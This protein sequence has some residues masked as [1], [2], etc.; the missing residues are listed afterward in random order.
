[1]DIRPYARPVSGPTVYA[2]RVLPVPAAAPVEPD[3]LLGPALQIEPVQVEPVQIEPA[4]I[5]P[6][7]IET[8]RSIETVR[9]IEPEPPETPFV[10]PQSPSTASPAMESTEPVLGDEPDLDLPW[11]T[12][13]L[14]EEAEPGPAS[15]ALL[16]PLPVAADVPTSNTNI[17]SDVSS[18][19]NYSR[20]VES[21]LLQDT[22]AK[23]SE[24]SMLPGVFVRASVRDRDHSRP[25]LAWR[26][27][28]LSITMSPLGPNGDDASDAATDPVDTGG[29]LGTAEVAARALESLAMRVRAGRVHLPLPISDLSDAAALAATLLA[30]LSMPK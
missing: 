20:V 13:Y 30:L 14:V 25:M 9:H 7:Q 23:L 19:P 17:G 28:D 29:V 15:S 8:V 18:T 24:F 21:W 3:V 2:A 1:M 5:E 12:A 6:A 26:D 16:H 10:Q 11:V 4:Q 27:E 22:A